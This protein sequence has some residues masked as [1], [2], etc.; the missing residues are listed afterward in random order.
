MPIPSGGG[1]TKRAARAPWGAPGMFPRICLAQPNHQKL[2]EPNAEH[3]V[4]HA[5]ALA[6]ALSTRSIGAQ[7]FA[8]T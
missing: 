8:A 3:G 5:L 7:S 1:G 4:H 6:A 2:R